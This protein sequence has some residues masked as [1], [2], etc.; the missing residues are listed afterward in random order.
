MTV[1]LLALA[2]GT[3]AFLLFFSGTDSYDV[4]LALDN[5]SQLVKGNQVKVGAVAV[6]SVSS[7][8]LGPDGRAKIE[9]SI[10]DTS[11]TPLHRGTRA[12]VRS[13]SLAGVA[14]RY[15]AVIPGPTNAPEIPSGG[16][17]PAEDTRSEV[18]LDAVLNALNPETLRDLK[19]LLHNGSAGLRGRGKELGRVL[20]ALDPALS[21]VDQLEREVLHDQG[22]FARFLVES[23]DVVSSVAPRR[24]ALERL[25]ASG[26]STLGELARHDAELDSL[27]RRLPPTLRTTNTTLV[28]L[29]AALTDIDPTIKLAQPVARPL[30][31]TLDRLRPVT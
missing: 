14:N 1:V 13:S 21:Q 31:E 30:A 28:N 5:A 9:L 15:V 18:D 20:E 4:N 27:L 10:D 19:L 11:V 17:I 24:P 3:I 8:E 6:G 29:R 22:T 12:E 23:A 26:H 7:L 25:V 2:I 16:A